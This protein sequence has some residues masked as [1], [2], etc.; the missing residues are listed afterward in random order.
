MS[1][2]ID[3][4]QIERRWPKTSNDHELILSYIR[5]C[6]GQKPARLTGCE[7]SSPLFRAPDFLLHT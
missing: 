6:P 5:K 3:N 2:V 7:R 4:M 1:I